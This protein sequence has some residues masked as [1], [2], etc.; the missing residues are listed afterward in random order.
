MKHHRV[1]IEQR[2]IANDVEV[3]MLHGCP[4]APASMWHVGE[5]LTEIARVTNVHLPGYDGS[6][7]LRPFVEEQVLAA[8]EQTLSDAGVRD[9]ILVGFSFGVFRAFELALRARIGIRGV[10]A[11]SGLS[12][13]TAEHRTGIHANAKAIRDPALDLVSTFT[14]FFLSEPGIA[15][16]D[17]RAQLATWFACVERADLCAE[18]DAVAAVPDLDLSALAIPV[19][20]R[21]GDAD[22]ATPVALTDQ[23]CAAVRGAERQIV[24]GVGHAIMLEDRDATQRAVATFVRRHAL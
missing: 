14:P 19:L 9:A 21:V 16:A 7:P 18:L 12:S 6:P 17:H 1:K 24:P 20:A 5:A 4:S 10:V 3:V 15:N 11:L 23:I 8:V 13:M 22:Q 2:G